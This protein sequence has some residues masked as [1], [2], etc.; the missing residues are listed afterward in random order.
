MIANTPTPNG[1]DHLVSI[2]NNVDYLVMVVGNLADDVEAI[3]RLVETHVTESAE[4]RE[5]LHRRVDPETYRA[6]L[7]WLSADRA[8]TGQRSE[9][10]GAS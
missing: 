5:P 4:A 1:D 9:D 2:R 10:E 3:R 6:A 7:S 8:Q